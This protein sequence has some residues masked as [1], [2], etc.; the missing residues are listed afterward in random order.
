MRV[1]FNPYPQPVKQSIKVKGVAQVVRM[2]ALGEE[3]TI[4]ACG[5]GYYAYFVFSEAVDRPVTT[6]QLVT[7]RAK[8][9]VHFGEAVNDLA[10]VCPNVDLCT[11]NIRAVARARHKE[12]LL[13]RCH[14]V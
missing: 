13:H 9:I 3:H 7:V 8:Q 4:A 6:K 2:K 10:G 11:I 14:F 5:S 12:G 1:V